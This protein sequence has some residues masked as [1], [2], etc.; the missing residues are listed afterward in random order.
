MEQVT[1]IG[2]D[3]AKMSFQAHGAGA[4]GSVVFRKALS[5]GKVLSFLE[6]QPR[7]VVAMEACASAHYWGREISRLGH[8]VRLI[9]PVYVKPFVKRQKNDAADAE[10]I[11]EA[12]SRPT[13]RFVAVKSEEKQALGMSFGARDL[14]VRQ[15]TQTI[16]ALRGHLA[17]FGLVVPQGA[18]HIG[19]LKGAVEE[20]SET[21]P[22]TVVEVATMLFEQVE[23]LSERIDALERR[24]RSRARED[25]E[26]R[27]RMA[28]PGVGVACA[29]AVEAFA[30]PMESFRSGRHFAAWL[31]LTPRQHS[32][33]GKAILGRTSRMGQGD[34]RR[35]LIIGAMSVVRWASR[36]GTKDPWL[37]SML[38]RKPRMLVAV[39]LANKMARIIWAISVKKE[40]YRAPA[41][42]A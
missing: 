10:A 3:L 28:V 31:G 42:V 40:D 21:L 1:I 17:E 36:N 9:P 19:R 23:A 11:A 32:T 34:I 12:A 2:L 33:G 39:A 41:A 7:C 13:M 8:E 6:G 4:D 26:T 24:I 37:A 25:E 15:R 22:E 16:N 30:P 38:Q 14:L 18:A 20:A 5:R 35:L 27:R 29:A